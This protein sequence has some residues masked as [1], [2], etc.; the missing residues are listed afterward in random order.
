MSF[1]R[2]IFLKSDL[3]QGINPNWLP[4]N[5]CSVIWIWSTLVTRQAFWQNCLIVYG[6]R[7]ELRARIIQRK[8][9]SRY[10]T[11]WYWA[12]EIVFFYVTHANI[13]YLIYWSFSQNLERE[14]TN[15]SAT[16]LFSC[17]KIMLRRLRLNF[18]HF[19]C[20]ATILFPRTVT[21]SWIDSCF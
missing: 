9:I 18:L 14:Y 4:P 20:F 6:F 3:W 8:T 10:K 21:F 2:R 11:L 17:L 15:C 7:L 5:R 12:K 19:R 16:N 13:F 1:T